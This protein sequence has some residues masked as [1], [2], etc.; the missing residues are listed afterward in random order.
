MKK[1]SAKLIYILIKKT[2]GKG[3]HRL[4]EPSFSKTEIKY[5]NKTIKMSQYKRYSDLPLTDVEKQ[6]REQ[7][8]QQDQQLEHSI[9]I[10]VTPVILVWEERED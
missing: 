3:P 4:H 5:I 10:A 1:I 7:Q 2:I 8:Q 9:I 6:Q